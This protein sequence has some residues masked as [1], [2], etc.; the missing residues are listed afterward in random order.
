[1][2]IR[3]NF[4]KILVLSLLFFGTLGKAAEYLNE[5][6][7]PRVADE[8]LIRIAKAI[9]VEVEEISAAIAERTPEDKNL[10]EICFRVGILYHL[11]RIDLQGVMKKEP[12]LT[13]PEKK[14]ASDSVMTARALPGFCG[15]KEKT[16]MDPGRVRI[17]KGDVDVLV[18]EL[19]A[20]DA[21]AKDLINGA[22]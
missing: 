21:K 2:D 7:P 15:D 5:V 4:I 20:L 1:M 13:E 19:K 11:A 10:E 16:S 17:T 12:P 22:G 8:R 6:R 18:G 14:Y 3:G 9:R